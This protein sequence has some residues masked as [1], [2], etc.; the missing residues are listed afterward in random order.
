MKVPWSRIHSWHCVACGE[1]CKHF[2]VP[3]TFWEYLRFRKLG[4]VEERRKYYLRKIGGRCPFQMGRLCGI[5][6]SKPFVCKLFPF[7]IRQKGDDSALFC[8]NDEEYY[9]YVDTYCRNI[10]FGKPSLK[11]KEM[12]REAL[13]IYTGK[14]LRPRLLTS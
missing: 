4:L 12:V 6:E 9:V 5:Q 3:L 8:Y 1:C 11:F 13:D 14:R 10:V 2:K 7:I